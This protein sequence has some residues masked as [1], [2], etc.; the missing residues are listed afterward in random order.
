MS[1]LAWSPRL[2]A[3][4]STTSL[5][6][7]RPRVGLLMATSMPLV[8]GLATIE[9]LNL[10]GINYTGPLWLGQWLAVVFILLA[11]KAL[12]RDSEVHFP[13][14]RWSVW[15]GF[16]FASLV[17]CDGPGGR[18]VQDAMQI[19]MPVFVG[20]LASMFVRTQHD[21]RLV[22][23]AFPLTLLL[24]LPATAADR[25]DLAESAGMGI[26]VRSMSLTAALIGCVFLSQMPRRWLGPLT[27][28]TLCLLVT[29]VTGSRMASLAL[30]VAPIFHPLTRSRLWNFLAGGVL[31]VPAIG[32]FYTP[33]FQQRFFYTGSGTFSD[34]FAGEFLS[35]GRFE[36]WPD[37]WDEAWLHP[38]LGAGVGTTFDFVPTV[39]PEMNHVHNDYLRIGFELGL[40]GLTIFLITVIWQLWDIRRC[41][42]NTQGPLREAYSACWLGMILLLITGLTDNTLIYNL[43]YTD[44]LFALLG[45]AYGLHSQ[46]RTNV[47]G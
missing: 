20:V 5:R 8:A 29:V 44:P 37:I 15:I 6:H 36:A 7:N 47:T 22:L 11:E 24:I 17:W 28:W 2:V 45:A 12:R 42:T 30:L 4:I 14:K 26:A 23:S 34:L 41:I 25:F 9:G 16:L 46:S 13:W 27:G 35:F 21:L 43:W 10:A 40:V 19:A 39:W 3:P 33:T 18:H 1:R 38:W 31:L 32:L